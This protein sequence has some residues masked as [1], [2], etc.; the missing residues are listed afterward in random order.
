MSEST[1]RPL[2][3]DARENQ[4]RLLRAAAHRFARDGTQAS[5][6]AIAQDA[7]VGIATLYRRFPTREQLVEATYR[8]E[9]ERAAASAETL[10]E[11]APPLDALR[12]WMRGFIDL[13]AVKYGM[14]DTLKAALA[15]QGEL[16]TEIRQSLTDALQRLLDAGGKAGAVRT[17]VEAFD[18]LLGLGGIALIAGAPN[19]APQAQK[20]IDLLIDGLR[21]TAG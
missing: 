12:D 6:K 10:L 7:G 14:A 5:L 9:V 19:Q 15:E 2:R 4:D 13:L 1:D 16:G 8:S 3:S 11:T 21:Y 20:L 18:V 17:D